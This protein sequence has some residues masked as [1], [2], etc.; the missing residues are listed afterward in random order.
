MANGYQYISENGLIIADTSEILA[1][2]QNEF[3]AAF[4]DDLI[5]TPDTPQGVLITGEVLARDGVVRNNAV[6]ANQINPNFAGGVFLDAILALTGSERDKATR[7]VVTATLTGVPT[8]IIPEGAI[9]ETIDGDQFSL[10]STVIIPLSGTIEGTFY[11]VEFGPIAAAPEALSVVVSG[12]LGWETVTNDAAATLGRETQSDQAA[13]GYRRNTLAIQGQGTPEAITSGLYA[14]EGVKSLQFRENKENS[15]QVID[16]ITLV[17]HSVWA[18]VDG[19][20]DRAVASMLLQKKGGGTNWNGSVEIGIQD[21]YSGQIYPVKFDRPTD[22]Q[23]Q[24]RITIRTGSPVSDP[25]AT[26]RRAVLDYA[27]GGLSDEPGFATGSSV[28]PYEIGGAVNRVTPPIFVTK[29]EV[30]FTE[31]TAWTTDTI[32]L[33]LNEIARIVEG[34]I[35]VVQE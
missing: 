2:V 32:E 34:A 26:V 12:V 15:T 14:V 21:E 25:V 7:S 31:P 9:A 19:G 8:T 20:T 28:S 23:V 33:E 22:V 3:K 1:E 27:N 17:A 29:V 10:A 11:S 5:V 16:G 4:G 13:R 30:S 6:L 24:T 35:I 18:C